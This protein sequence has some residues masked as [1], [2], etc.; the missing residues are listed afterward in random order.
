MT[1]NIIK[2]SVTLHHDFV[3]SPKDNSIILSCFDSAFCGESNYSLCYYYYLYYYYFDQ[4]I[5]C[6][7][8]DRLILQLAIGWRSS[9]DHAVNMSG[10]HNIMFMT[11]SY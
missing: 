8:L 1:I 6:L 9:I 5:C 3:A 7:L 2:Q 4:Y 11:I 10:K